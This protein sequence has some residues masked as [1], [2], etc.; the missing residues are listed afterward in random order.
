MHEENGDGGF[1]PADYRDEWKETDAYF[2]IDADKE[3][4]S[5]LGKEQFT[6]IALRYA[7][8]MTYDEI[9]RRTGLSKQWACQLEKKAIAALRKNERLT[10]LLADSMSA[11]HGWA[12]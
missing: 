1:D 4:E 8:S 12:K 11:R 5:V 6:I 7:K 10:N 9:A 2:G 3:M